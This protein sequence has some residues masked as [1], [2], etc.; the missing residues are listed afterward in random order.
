[1]MSTNWADTKILKLK[2]KKGSHDGRHGMMANAL[3]TLDFNLSL[4][5][6]FKGRANAQRAKSNN[7]LHSSTRQVEVDGFRGKW[8]DHGWVLGVGRVT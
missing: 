7:K 6:N 3:L 1:L 8:V 5:L 4:N 2:A